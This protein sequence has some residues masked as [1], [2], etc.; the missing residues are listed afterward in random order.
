MVNAD[1]MEFYAGMLHP[2]TSAEHVLPMIALA[3]LASRCGPTAVRLA[4]QSFPPSLAFGIVAGSSF[5]FPCIFHAANLAALMTFGILLMVAH[6]LTPIVAAGAAVVLAS[7]AR[8][9]GG[10]G[11]GRSVGLLTEESFMALVSAPN[12]SPVSVASALVAAML[13]GATHALTPGHG[14]ALVG[15]HL[16]GSRGTALHAFFLG[17]TVTVTHTVVVFVAG[18]RDRSCG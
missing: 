18:P 9:G 2:V 5:P 15:A 17:L 6:R 10:A 12:L 14:K 8:L 3:L 4:V 7:K 11:G 16:V 13:R 1:V